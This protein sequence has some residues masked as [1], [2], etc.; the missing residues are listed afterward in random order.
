[1]PVT[2]LRL[3]PEGDKRDIPKP[4]P[5]Q[6]ANGRI[7]A[8]Q[9]DAVIVA[10]LRNPTSLQFG[11]DGKLYVAEQYGLIKVFT[12]SYN[13][14][15][16]SYSVIGQEEINLIKQIP[17]HNDNGAP[18]RTPLLPGRSPALWWAG[19]ATAPIVYV[20]SSDPRYGGRAHT[21]TLTWIPTRALSPA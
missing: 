11:P 3:A 15:D 5:K 8:V 9:Q 18:L 10:S 17:N 13:A 1:M 2:I 14:A 7:A 16:G 20:S 21:A 12:V 19:T 6:S 4:N